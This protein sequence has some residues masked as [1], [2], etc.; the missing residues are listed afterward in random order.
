M[1]HVLEKIEKHVEKRI[2]NIDETYKDMVEKLKKPPKTEGD[3]VVL[4]KYI[5]EHK[6][7]LVNLA[8]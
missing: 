2:Q 4:K 6:E 3:W 8:L 5:K 7:K 1:N